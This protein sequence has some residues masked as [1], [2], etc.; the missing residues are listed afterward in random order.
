MHSTDTAI[1]GIGAVTSYGWGVSSLWEGLISGKPAARLTSGFGL[2]PHEAGW[3]GRVPDGGRSSDGRTRF[4]RAFRAAA[5]EAI[6]DADRR[7]WRPGRR[8]G[9]LHGLV[10]GDV[11]TVDRFYRTE[12]G[13]FKTRPEFLAMMT[14]S[15]MTGMMREFEFHGPVMDIGAMCGSGNAALITAKMWLDAGF[16]DDVVVI[17]TDL[18]ATR[19]IVRGF[20]DLNVAITDVAPLDACRPFQVGSKGFPFAEA[21]MAMVLSNNGTDH[22]AQMLGGSM[23]HEAHHVIAIDPSAVHLTSVVHHALDRAGVPPH[24]VRY[25]HAHGPGTQQCDTAETAVLE[26]IFPTTTQI[27][28][29]KPTAGHNQSA[30]ALVEIA[31]S[32]LAWQR[33]LIP[34]PR[35]VA[36]AHPQLLDGPTRPDDG[37]VVKSSLGL[38]GQNSAIVLGPPA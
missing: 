36:S 23:T 33:D 22:Y 32:C 8:V 11:E 10:L 1:C 31:A 26:S 27:Y 38:G 7:G 18:S 35:Q 24:S 20:A 30:A 6:E 13:H 3:V 37:Y 14:S 5:R 17:T 16:A 15:P 4:M 25:L 2:D 29:I 21:S 34:A 28:S 12:G 9:V 19:P